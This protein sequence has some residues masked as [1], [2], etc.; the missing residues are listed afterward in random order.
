MEKKRAVRTNI[1]KQNTIK[2]DD[3]QREAKKL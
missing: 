3:K 1:E 2:A